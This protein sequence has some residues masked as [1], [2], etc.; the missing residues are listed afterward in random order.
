MLHDMLQARRAITGKVA[1]KTFEG[2][3]KLH[4]SPL[5]AAFLAG[6]ASGAANALPRLALVA[7]AGV[8]GGKKAAAIT[9]LGTLGV[10]ALLVQA[11]GLNKT[12]PT[13]AFE[14]IQTVAQAQAA[15]ERFVRTA[16][17]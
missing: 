9:H 5:T 16:F 8:V 15:A 7:V 14:R 3:R 4:V 2:L 13:D 10:E 12:A 17:A 11:Y 1:L 6:A